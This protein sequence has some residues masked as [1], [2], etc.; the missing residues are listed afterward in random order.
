MNLLPG[1]AG[2]SLHGSRGKTMLSLRR[3]VLV[4]SLLAVA[5]L[6]ALLW[7]GVPRPAVAPALPSPNGYDDLLRAAAV[8][9][10]TVDASQ[11]STE[12]L[13][14]FVEGNREALRLARVGLNRACQVPVECSQAYITAHVNELAGLKALVQALRAEG[15]LAERE[16]RP[17][18]A[19]QS[20]L[21]AM[22][23]G[24]QVAR[25]GML[26]DQLVGLAC[27]AIGMSPLTNLRTNL[28]AQNW[29]GVIQT[30]EAIE[31]DQEPLPSML[32]RQRDWG[33]RLIG[34][35]YIVYRVVDRF[36]SRAL[37]QSDEKFR[38][39]HQNLSAR[40]RLL[41]AEGAVRCYWLE[42]HRY[43]DSLR[44]LVPGLL[45]AVPADPYTE[46]SLIYRP[47]AGSFLLYSA[48]P[49]GKD[50]RG[51]PIPKNRGPYPP[52]G[53]IFLDSPSP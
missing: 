21:D 43:P 7:R 36:T 34:A 17:S 30:L 26:I 52:K 6:L 50:D 29:R 14:A 24:H 2:V 53:D 49:D 48:G 41:L 23:L 40:R 3:K 20:Y 28:S 12:E 51:T 8:R 19:V 18:D 35:K 5:G 31:R 16:N 39:K 42:N 11:A 46:T 45:R 33:R 37:E 22:R 32:A 27:Q 44:E 9:P 38:R 47:Q 4:V 10:S 13:Q 15:A 1:R 25:G